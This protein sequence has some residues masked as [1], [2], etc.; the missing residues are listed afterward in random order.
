MR[1]F[2]W[3]L[4]GSL[5][6]AAP[7]SAEESA[8]PTK[9]TLFASG[10]TALSRWSHYPYYEHGPTNAHA[11]ELRELIRDADLAMT[12]LE[13]VFAT[14]GSYFDKG[15]RRPYLYR[16]RPEMLDVITEVGYDLVVTANNH[17][18][19][20]GP[21]ALLE[22]HELLAAVGIAQVGSGANA[23]EAA[24]PTFMKVGDVVIA[25]IALE[26]HFPKFG[27]TDDRAGTN[28]A[29]GDRAVLRSVERSVKLARPHADLVVFT[30]HWGAN[31]TENMTPGR[32]K[33]ARG[34]ID[35]G[36]DAILGHSSH[37]LHGIEV[38]K[39]RPIVYDMGSFYF[40]RVGQGRMRYS[41]GF[42]L[43]FD[44]EGFS[45]LTIHP[46]KLGRDRTLP[47]KGSDL[48]R[49]HRII[50]D[51]SHEIDPE[52]EFAT[53]GDNLVLELA[54]DPPPPARESLPAKLFEPGRTSRLSDELRARKSNVLFD[55]PPAFTKDF[56]PVKLERGVTILG[57][58]SSDG[59]RSGRAFAAEVVLAVEGPLE[60]TWIGNIK[61]EQENRSKPYVWRHPIADGAWVPAIWEPGQIGAN[62]TLVRP[63]KLEEGRYTL[64]FALVNA[65]TRKSLKPLDPSRGD[66]KGFV[67][68][69]EVLIKNRG[70]PRGAAGV[71]WDGKLRQK[72]DGEV[73]PV[74]PPPDE[75]GPSVV[76]LLVVIGVIALGTIIVVILKRRKR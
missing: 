25:F 68:F 9:H 45:K 54:P 41:A 70:I 44:A 49:I 62:R 36:V 15:E 42:V 65:E 33:L 66:S 69:S 67:P 51:K 58:D 6:G 74:N 34:I 23:E 43:E 57:G 52:I 21:E 2:T 20:Y 24:R 28:H 46:V 56:E 19:D 13:C 38:Y 50:T 4:L 5:L 7:A 29:E 63:P 3:L 30:P 71:A 8:V 10:D 73:E 75:Q 48:R 31:W 12:N 39:G 61:V 16:A 37:H 55:E 11:A 22:E 72:D 27:A 35:L 18:M 40:D 26:P 53:V 47:A 14:T 32:R 64:S 1:A 59:A 60:G 17:A 76:V